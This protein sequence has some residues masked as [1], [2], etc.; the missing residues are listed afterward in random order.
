MYIINDLLNE[1]S[2]MFN[3]LEGSSWATWT[4]GHITQKLQ[5]YSN[6]MN[7]IRCQMMD[8]MPNQW[9]IFRSETWADQANSTKQP[10]M[11]IGWHERKNSNEIDTK[12]F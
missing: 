8:M 9:D 3:M 4:S 11:N 2:I 10:E 7:I 1:H 5:L 12:N 6:L